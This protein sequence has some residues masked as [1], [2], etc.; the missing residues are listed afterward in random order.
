MYHICMIPISSCKLIEQR[1]RKIIIDVRR[2]KNFHWCEI[3]V[4]MLNFVK[5]HDGSSVIDK[6]IIIYIYII[7]NY[8]ILFPS[9]GI[10]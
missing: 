2:I 10:P 6:I 3:M 9:F 4:E 8:K 7:S 5:Y 1:D